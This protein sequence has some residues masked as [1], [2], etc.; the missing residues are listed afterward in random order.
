MI[1]KN[2][3]GVEIGNCF[4]RFDH[5]E[6]LKTLNINLNLLIILYTQDGETGQLREFTNALKG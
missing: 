5:D 6:D 1:D 2:D 3:I 4:V